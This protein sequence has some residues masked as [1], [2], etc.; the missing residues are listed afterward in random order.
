MPTNV[1]NS[2]DTENSIV[3]GILI[4]G[5]SAYG[6]YASA[7]IEDP[8][9]R[10]FSLTFCLGVSIVMLAKTIVAVIEHPNHPNTTRVAIGAYSAATMLMLGYGLMHF[11]DP[12]TNGSAL[13]SFAL[14]LVLG[15]P[16][17]CMIFPRDHLDLMREDV[18]MAFAWA[19]R[20]I[21]AYNPFA[22]TG[23]A[24]LVLPD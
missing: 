8:L 18:Q 6:T 20:A 15:M 22:T 3:P 1:I 17:F 21:Q 10:F 19:G 9:L 13:F 16:N 7:G 2:E 23:T 11:G 24:A 12:E 14:G 4:F 5:L